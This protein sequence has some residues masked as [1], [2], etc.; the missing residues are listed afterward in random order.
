ML[1]IFIDRNKIV[2]M[3]RKVHRES[4][5]AILSETA[6]QIAPRVINF[7]KSCNLSLRLEPR[8]FVLVSFVE[9]VDK[10]M[11]NATSPGCLNQE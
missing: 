4:N 7:R 3:C 8:V 10:P 9:V 6:K 5:A 11:L 1:L 2:K